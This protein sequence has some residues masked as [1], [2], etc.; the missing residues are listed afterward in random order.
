VTPINPKHETVQGLPCFARLADA[1][2]PVDLAVIATPAAT[3]PAIIHDCGAHGV[4]AAVV[5]SAGFAA[6]G[7]GVDLHDAVMRA[8]RDHGLRV[9]GP[10][11][12][13]IIAPHAHFNATFS[14]NMAAPGD[15]ALV[16]QSGAICTAVLDWARAR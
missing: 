14:K 2:R 5:L 15:L 11:C 7:H 16:S 3:V 9:L 10:N 1:G 13:G 6:G 4:R 12:V 8:A